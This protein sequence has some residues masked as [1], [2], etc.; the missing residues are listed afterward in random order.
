MGRRIWGPVANLQMLPVSLSV[1]SMLG[2]PPIRLL[3]GW[4]FL[5]DSFSGRWVLHLCLDS[6]S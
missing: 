5:V 6:V 2:T 4:S 3:G 1:F